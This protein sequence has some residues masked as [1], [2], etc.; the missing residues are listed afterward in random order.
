M[1]YICTDIHGLYDRYE[2]LLEKLNLQD[3]D[4]LYVLGDM[5]DRGPDGIKILQDMM[6]RK[7]IVPF[8]G[9]HEHMMLMYLF[10]HDRKSWLFPVNGGDVTLAE[11][12]KLSETEQA[13]II[14]YLSSSYV[15]K[16]LNIKGHRYVLSHIGIRPDEEDLIADFTNPETDVYDL[17]KIVWGEKPYHLSA[18]RDYPE[19]LC[20]TDFMTGHIITARWQLFEGE[21]EA[22]VS[23]FP[24]GCRYFD[25]DCGCAMGDGMGRLAC[26]AISE[27]TG[28]P[29]TENII[30]VK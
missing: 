10:W 18:I 13:E 14:S 25:L 11:F 16:H 9:N 22:I 20:P 3:Q 28:E 2:K 8:L 5:I 1:I 7:N 17:Q 15:I 24:N 19:H 29:D 21:D 23:V 4:V 27:E 6:K 12:L 30:Y 26:L